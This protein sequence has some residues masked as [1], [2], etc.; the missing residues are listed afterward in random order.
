MNATAIFRSPIKKVYPESACARAVLCISAIRLPRTNEIELVDKVENIERQVVAY[1]IEHKEFQNETNDYNTPNGQTPS[2]EESDDHRNGVGNG[3]QHTVSRISLCKCLLPIVINHHRGV[4]QYFPCDFYTERKQ[5][6]RPD[7]KPREEEPYTNIEQEA[8]QY[9][10]ESVPIT[11]VL[12][13]TRAQHYSF[14]HFH[15]PALTDAR[16]PHKI[17]S[18]CLHYYKRHSPA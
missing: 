4:F 16:L 6:P 7:G 14:P 11:E 9:V 10:A 12:R 2:R 1:H 18:N 13:I 15:E 3:V 8:V 17:Q 5:E